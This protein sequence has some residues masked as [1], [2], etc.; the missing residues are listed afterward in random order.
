[1]KLV[2]AFDPAEEKC[3]ELLAHGFDVRS[4]LEIVDRL[5]ARLGGEAEYRRAARLV[6]Q[7]ALDTRPKDPELKPEWF[8]E[9]WKSDE[10]Q[11][12]WGKVGQRISEMIR[13]VFKVNADPE[14]C[15]YLDEGWVYD[16]RIEDFDEVAT[17]TIDR[18][19]GKN[20]DWAFFLSSFSCAAHPELPSNIWVAERFDSGA[21]RM[22]IQRR[23]QP[24]FDCDDTFGMTISD[25]PE[26]V[27]DMG[28]ELTVE[29]IA[30]FK[31]FIVRNKPTLLEHWNNVI[32]TE[33]VVERLVF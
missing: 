26:I 12:L 11:V 15:C 1:M 5:A 16:G 19:E 10:I 24:E 17:R 3:A 28:T 14:A 31:R 25:T 33:A 9:W 2:D 6:C 18:M 29:D 22:L 4:Y 8:D 32:G 13:G 23:K 21:P 27:G 20:P 7:E 30:Y